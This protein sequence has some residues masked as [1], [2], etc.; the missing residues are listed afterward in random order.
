MI[1]RT[2]TPGDF[3]FTLFAGSQQV[4]VVIIPA[5]PIGQ[6]YNFHA[7]QDSSSFDR[8][9]VQGPGASDGRVVMDNLQI[10]PVPEPCTVILAGIGIL[11]LAAKA[12]P[13][14]LLAHRVESTLQDRDPIG[15]YAAG[16]G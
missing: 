10:G 9:I 15:C 3:T 6:V 13:L 5:G 11:S 2:V 7:F 12:V 4:D 14:R 8:V 16:K 1:G